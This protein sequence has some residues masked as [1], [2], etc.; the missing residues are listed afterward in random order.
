MTS[1]DRAIRL[2]PPGEHDNE[3]AVDERGA[4]AEKNLAAG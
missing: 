2:S 4:R 1:F 3:R